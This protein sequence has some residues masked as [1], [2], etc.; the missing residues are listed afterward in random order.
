MRS[1]FF[2]FKNVRPL[3]AVPQDFQ[4]RIEIV[5]RSV[6]TDKHIKVRKEL[7]CRLEVCGVTNVAH[8]EH[9]YN[10]LIV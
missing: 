3:R 10:S 7:A 5:V 2:G 4:N 6:P 8:I 9:L 1:L